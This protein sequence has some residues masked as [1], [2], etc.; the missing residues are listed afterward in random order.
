MAKRSKQRQSTQLNRAAAGIGDAL[1][2]IAARVDSWKQQRSEIAAEIRKLLGTGQ[3]LLRDL[4]HDASATFE[5]AR[6]KGGRP[7]GYKMSE[8]TKRKLRAAWK[9]RK[10]AA[11][12]KVKSAQ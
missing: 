6:R 4:G 1:G 11:A 12:A 7:K 3:T 9:R 2:Q 10:A 5:A 8:D